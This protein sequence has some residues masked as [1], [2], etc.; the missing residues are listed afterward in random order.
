MTLIKDV[1]TAQSLFVRWFT[2]LAWAHLADVN[3]PISGRALAQ[4][5][6]SE[7]SRARKKQGSQRQPAA[8]HRNG[9]DASSGLC[10]NV[11]EKRGSFRAL[12]GSR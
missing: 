8:E 9:A 4:W 2:M 7:S 11:A 1:G 10:D 6:I 12:D 5:E 3:S